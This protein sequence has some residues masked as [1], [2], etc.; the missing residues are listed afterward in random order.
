M[1]GM[2]NPH[3][4]SSSNCIEM[5]CLCRSHRVVAVG[6]APV[7]QMVGKQ[8]DTH[9]KGLDTTKHCIR[10]HLHVLEAMAMVE[11]RMCFKKALVDIETCLNRLIAVRMQR[12]LIASL[13]KR[14]HLLVDLFGVTEPQAIR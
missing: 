3:A 5:T 7:V 13:V 2:R 4:H 11:P 14:K 10:C 12:Q 6:I 1:N 8:V 9:A